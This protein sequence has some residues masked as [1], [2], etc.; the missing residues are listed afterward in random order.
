MEH[1][2]VELVRGPTQVSLVCSGE[3]D[4]S[5]ADDLVERAQEALESHPDQLVLDLSEANFLDSSGLNSLIAI[6][7]LSESIGVP[8]VLRPGSP[9][10]MRVFS[11]AG[12]DTLFPLV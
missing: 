1:Y 7:K 5:A 6:H 9:R 12:L 4:L 10:V 3:L 11:L 8:V 2:Q